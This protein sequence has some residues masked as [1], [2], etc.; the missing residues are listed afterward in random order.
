MGSKDCLM[1]G[2]LWRRHF[3]RQTGPRREFRGRRDIP[4]LN[5]GSCLLAQ[6]DA[7][8]DLRQVRATD[9]L[10]T[11]NCIAGVISVRTYAIR[12]S[13]GEGAMSDAENLAQT[14]RPAPKVD[15]RSWVKG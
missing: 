8:T 13:R 3:R 14:D 4:P 2:K 9:I 7:R 6:G 12:Q 11:P 10:M 15:R 1:S 5:R